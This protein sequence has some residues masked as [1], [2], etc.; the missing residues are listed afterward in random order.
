[1]WTPLGTHRN[2]TRVGAAGGGAA[3]GAIASSRGS[4]IDAPIPRSAVRR[5]VAVH[6]LD[7]P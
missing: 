7:L 1:M 4:A 3:A 2:A 5:E 6:G